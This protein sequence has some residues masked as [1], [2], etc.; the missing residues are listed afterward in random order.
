[1]NDITTKFHNLVKQLL[2][3]NSHLLEIVTSRPPETYTQKERMTIVLD[4]VFIDKAV[5]D[6]KEVAKDE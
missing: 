5:N 2:E 1:M 4:Q 6:L 3:A